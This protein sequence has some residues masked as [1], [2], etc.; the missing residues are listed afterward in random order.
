MF[1]AFTHSWKE[2]QENKLNYELQF[3]ENNRING[4]EFYYD[5]SLDISLFYYLLASTFKKKKKKIQVF[6]Q[7][8][9][10]Y[11]YNIY[12]EINFCLVPYLMAY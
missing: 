7:N 8:F 9:M 2:R 6:V 12:M 10:H 1:T 11:K 5:A 4:I 3:Q